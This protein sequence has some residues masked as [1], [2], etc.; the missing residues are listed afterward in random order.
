MYWLAI[1]ETKCSL[2]SNPQLP[3]SSGQCAG[4][5]E[6]GGLAG[7]RNQESSGRA[8]P[9]LSAVTAS[10]ARFLEDCM[11][12]VAAESDESQRVG[13][14]ISQDS[15][16]MEVDSKAPAESSGQHSEGAD[17]KFEQNPGPQ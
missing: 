1:N 6:N 13:T 10:H 11:R 2:N 9:K 5:R 12:R 3:A 15:G 17:A 16:E 7:L 4:F 14:N 8:R